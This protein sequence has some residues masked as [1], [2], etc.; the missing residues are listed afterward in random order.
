MNV[1]SCLGAVL[2][3]EQCLLLTRE[4]LRLLLHDQFPLLG[5]VSL[6]IL[7]S[8]SFHHGVC[9]LADI[10]GNLDTFL[11]YL[12]LLGFVSILASL[13]QLLEYHLVLS[14]ALDGSGIETD[15]LQVKSLLLTNLMIR[16]DSLCSN[17]R[18]S[19][20]VLKYSSY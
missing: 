17:L 20:N 4:R 19:F 11:K 14:Q 8:T 3:P 6:K 16:S 18:K 12:G 10:V 7:Y 2:Y 9:L 13:H 1:L 5:D 15:N